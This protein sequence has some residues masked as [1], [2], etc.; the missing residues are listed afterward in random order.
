[1]ILVVFFSLSLRQDFVAVN[2]VNCITGRSD[3]IQNPES[4]IQNPVTKTRI[5]CTKM[6]QCTRSTA[7]RRVVSF[8]VIDQQTNFVKYIP[9][10]Y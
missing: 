6:T 7:T 8:E 5:D 3:R 9:L 2:Q 1:M 10:K 4:R